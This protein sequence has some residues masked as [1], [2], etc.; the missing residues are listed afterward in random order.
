MIIMSAIDLP[1][2]GNDCGDGMVHRPFSRSCV[3]FFFYFKGTEATD[4]LKLILM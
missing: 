3:F 4:I 1:G 2:H